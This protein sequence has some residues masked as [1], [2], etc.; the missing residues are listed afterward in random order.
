MPDIN[1]LAW[2]VEQSGLSLEQDEWAALTALHI[3]DEILQLSTDT[4]ERLFQRAYDE[5]APEVYGKAPPE[6]PDEE[7]FK[8]KFL[9]YVGD[10]RDEL[11]QKVCV[12]LRYCELKKR[13]K[14]WPSVIQGIMMILAILVDFAASAGVASASWMVTSGLLDE[15]C[16]CSP[17]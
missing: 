16:K 13:W 8:Q 10:R 4:R 12:E 2:A 11:H 1:E 5:M 3:D 17:T 9:E 6:R 15:L 14:S 7:T